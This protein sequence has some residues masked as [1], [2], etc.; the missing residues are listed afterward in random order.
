MWVGEE[1]NKIWG[2][3]RQATRDKPLSPWALKGR[4]HTTAEAAGQAGRTHPHLSSLSALQARSVCLC[5]SFSFCWFLLLA[6]WKQRST[7]SQYGAWLMRSTGSASGEERSLGNGGQ[8]G[9]N[10]EQ[11]ITNAV[12]I[13]ETSMSTEPCI[14][15]EVTNPAIV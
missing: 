3:L 2:A 8:G 6:K 7:N 5:L 15:T 12:S 14:R 9:E 13:F 11:R 4:G 1:A 10:R